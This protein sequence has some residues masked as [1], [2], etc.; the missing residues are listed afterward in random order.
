[1]VKTKLN[2]GS[3]MSFFGSSSST[4]RLLRHQEAVVPWHPLTVPIKASVKLSCTQLFVAVFHYSATQLER[5]G[6]ETVITAASQDTSPTES[7]S[8]LVKLPG[9]TC[10]HCMKRCM[11]K[12]KSSDA[13]QCERWVHASCE[14]IPKE[15]YKL[16]N[17]VVGEIPNLVY[18]CKYNQC[19]SHLNQFTSVANHD[20]PVNISQ[21]LKVISDQYGVLKTTVSKLGSQIEELSQN[22]LSLKKKFND[23]LSSQKQ[24]QATENVSSSQELSTATTIA[25]EL[26]ERERKKEKQHNHL[27]LSRR[28]SRKRETSQPQSVIS[29]VPQG[30]V[31]GPLLFL[32]YINDIPTVVKSKIKLYAD[33]TSLYRNINSEEDITILQQYLNSLSQWAK[34]WQMNFNPSKCKC[35]R[36]SNKSNL[37]NLTYHIDCTNIK[38]VEYA[39]YLRVTIDQKLNWHE[40]INNVVKKG[41]SVLG[42]LQRNLTNCPIA[43]KTSCYQT[44]LRPVLEYASVVWL[45]H[46]QTDID[47]LEMVQRRSARFVLNK[48]DRYASVTKM[49]E[50][51]GWPSL[52]SRRTNAKLIM[53]YK[54]INDIVDVDI[55]DNILVPVTCHYTRGHL[56]QPYTRVDAYKYSYMP[57]SIKLWNT[58]PGDVTKQNSVENFQANLHT[59]TL[60]I[61]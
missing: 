46:Y 13:I 56:M 14:G 6:Y 22:N 31:L 18:C 52:Q 15:K 32:C 19:Y 42:F 1:M 8:K 29:G 41:N 20:S 58:L 47:R 23:L 50:S 30:S 10:S 53:F 36:I 34:K 54:I 7:Q 26:A 60:V 55:D 38:Q 37:L 35:L 59:H 11:S 5:H 40:H 28:H 24:P 57:S 45:P 25:E 9:D 3:Q 21:D 49:M 39:K 2:C 61:N 17:Q 4:F 27:Q 33:D 16:F 12:G 51:L 44:Y 43:V 48:K